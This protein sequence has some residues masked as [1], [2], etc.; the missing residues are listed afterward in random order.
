[1]ACKA[2]KQARKKCSGGDPCEHC[3]RHEVECVYI[4]DDDGRRKEARKRKIQ[5]LE[6]DSDLL[7][8]LLET[9][10]QSGDDEIAQIFALVRGNISM[11]NVKLRL[12]RRMNEIVSDRWDRT[13]A[14]AQV[15]QLQED[16]QRAVTINPRLRSSGTRVLK[17]DQLLDTS[18]SHMPAVP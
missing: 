2:C 3:G 10:Q 1:M 18:P 16:R 8:Q 6:S 4:I 5:D 13:H 12:K 11:E 7:H 17:I 14:H 15:G 9:I